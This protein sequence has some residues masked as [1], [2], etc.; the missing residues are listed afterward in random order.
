MAQDKVYKYKECSSLLSLFT[1]QRLDDENLNFVFQR[2]Y[3]ILAS[4]ECGQITLYDDL[5]RE[6][7]LNK[8]RTQINK[9]MNFISNITK[10][11]NFK[12]GTNFAEDI[13]FFFN[14]GEH[15]SKRNLMEQRMVKSYDKKV[16][17]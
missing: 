15:N 7:F 11:K 10:I 17:Y 12:K 9:N 6:L 4:L 1:E 14:L 16:I 3:K 2:I 13:N 5:F 8:Y